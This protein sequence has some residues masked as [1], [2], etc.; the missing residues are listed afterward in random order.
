[1]VFYGFAWKMQKKLWKS[2]Q[3]FRYKK[4]FRDAVIDGTLGMCYDVAGLEACNKLGFI[5]LFAPH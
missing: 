5:V 4:D 2:M 3:E 1:M